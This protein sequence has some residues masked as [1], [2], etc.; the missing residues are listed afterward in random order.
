MNKPETETFDV[1]A[2]SS[3]TFKV[4]R[5][6]A[7]NKTADNAEAIVEMAVTRRGCET[8][9]YCTAPAGLYAVG[10]KFNKLP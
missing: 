9:F 7:R 3:E 6:L 8:E 2:L 5:I 4:E 1:I 10:D